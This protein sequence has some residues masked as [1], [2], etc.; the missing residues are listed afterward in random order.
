VT[1]TPDNK[2]GFNFTDLVPHIAELRRRIIAVLVVLFISTAIAFSLSSYISAFL[3]APLSKFEIDLHTF[4]PAEK[5]MTYLHLSFWTGIV[6]TLPFFCLQTAFFIW[7]GLRGKEKRY[8]CITL[9]IVPVLFIL[10]AALCYH[11]LAP[12]AINFFLFFAEGDGMIPLWGF[13]QYLSL[14]FGLMLAGGLL[15]QGPFALLVLMATGLV[16]YK[17]VARFR[18]HIILLIFLLAALLTPPDVISQI[19]LG[20][21]LYLLFEGT[22]FL[23]RIF[24]NR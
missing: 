8:A 20:V 13:R 1:E 5:F 18:P 17:S 24:R 2:E 21:P 10:G 16:S 9:F 22:L 15:L 12:I 7:P 19:M 11:F 3:L 14:L 23:G 6:C 4:A